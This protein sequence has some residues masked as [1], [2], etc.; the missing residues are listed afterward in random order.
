MVEKFL[1]EEYD[2]L[3]N[4]GQMGFEFQLRDDM[5]ETASFIYDGRSCAILLRNDA[6]AYIFPGIPVE[7]REK[8]MQQ[9]EVMMIEEDGDEI[10]SSYM[11]DINKVPEIPVGD[12][13]TDDVTDMLEDIRAIY[14]EE[15]VKIIAEGLW[16][17]K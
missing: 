14:G 8:L 6:K 16:Q 11:S 1:I 3:E 13:L 15:G 12:M 2:V 4:Q 10:V 17:I 9:S 5:I 7:V